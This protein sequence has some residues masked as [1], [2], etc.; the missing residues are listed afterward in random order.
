MTLMKRQRL[1]Q[2]QLI[3]DLKRESVETAGEDNFKIIERG[4]TFSLSEFH[5]RMINGNV[6]FGKKPGK[7]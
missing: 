1:S 4:D 5:R 3:L 7:Q 6:V 2:F